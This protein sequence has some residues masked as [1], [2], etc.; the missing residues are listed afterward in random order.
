MVDL[1]AQV[2]CMVIP[3]PFGQNRADKATGPACQSRRRDNCRERASGGDHGSGRY[4]G[5]NIHQ[6]ADQPALG[7]ADG[8]R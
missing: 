2:M 8:L 7:A 3:N 5:S 6:S 1:L 4:H